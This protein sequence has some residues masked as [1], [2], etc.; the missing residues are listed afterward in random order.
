MPI[1]EKSRETP[2]EFTACALADRELSSSRNPWAI[3]RMQELQHNMTMTPSSTYAWGS[4]GWTGERSPA[5]SH[6]TVL[7]FPGARLCVTDTARQ[8]KV[9]RTVYDEEPDALFP[10][11]EKLRRTTVNEALAQRFRIKTP[12]DRDR[13][14]LP[15]LEEATVEDIH[16]LCDRFSDWVAK[17]GR[18]GP[19]ARPVFHAVLCFATSSS[20]M[21]SPSVSLRPCRVTC[22][23]SSLRQTGTSSQ[24]TGILVL[25]GESAWMLGKGERDGKMESVE[26]PEASG[27]LCS[28]GYIV[29]SLPPYWAEEDEF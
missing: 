13:L 1:T 4:W 17:R 29:P 12:E 23:R 7:A 20:S 24:L 3:A 15:S 16:A 2:R 26:N 22:L 8:W 6:P 5:P 9:L 10:A 21:P 11:V 19:L 14:N 18:G 27:S 28:T 25:L